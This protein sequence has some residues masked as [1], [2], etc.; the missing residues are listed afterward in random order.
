MMN[1]NT[2]FV[3]SFGASNQIFWHGNKQ[4]TRTILPKKV[5]MEVINV[6]IEPK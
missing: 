4:H 1:K 6:S 5:Y 2:H 3:E